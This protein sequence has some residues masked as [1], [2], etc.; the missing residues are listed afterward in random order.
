[1]LSFRER[2]CDE[3]VIRGTACEAGSVARPRRVLAASVLGSSMAFVDGTVVNV[4]LPALQGAFDA[5]ASGVQWVV[6][7]YALFL[8]SLLLVGGALGDRYGRRR[9]FS[10]GVAAFALAS[11]ACGLAQTLG[12]LVAA[13]AVQGVAGA[14]LV[15]GSLALIGSSFTETE[16]GRAIGIWSAFSAMSAGLGLLAGGWLLD[17]ASWRVVFFL[18]VP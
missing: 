12:Q 2:P 16:R 11:V 5:T 3:G 13:R 15:P 7:A 9:V 8:A 10:I 17:V 1:M 4:A 14:L 6:E 18:N